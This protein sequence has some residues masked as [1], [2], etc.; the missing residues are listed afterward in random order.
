MSG[1]KLTL[2]LDKKI[3]KNAKHYSAQ[4][5]LSLSKL[6]GRFFQSL[7]H[8][9]GDFSPIV[10]RLLGILPHNIDVREHKKH[11]EKKYKI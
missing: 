5:K 11:L 6:M 4:H 3:I 1:T 8:R 9:E 7:N 10:S 2:S